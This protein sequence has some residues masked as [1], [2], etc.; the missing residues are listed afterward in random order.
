MQV[1]T[2]SSRE[3]ERGK[4]ICLENSMEQVFPHSR[5]FRERRH[6]RGGDINLLRENSCAETG[7]RDEAHNSKAGP[8]AHKSGVT[9]ECSR[10]VQL[11][12]SVF[13]TLMGKGG[14]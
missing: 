7:K 3:Q 11:S 4:R 12:V 6:L 2:E 5:Y 8:P 10:F 1:L 9:W 14:E 13:A